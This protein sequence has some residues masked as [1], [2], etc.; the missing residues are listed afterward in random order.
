M[1]PAQP[2]PGVILYGFHESL[3]GMPPL[4]TGVLYVRAKE[5]LHK[6]EQKHNQSEVSKH[7]KSERYVEQN[8]AQAGLLT[9]PGA[10]WNVKRLSS[11]PN[12]IV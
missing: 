12:S 5:K 3:T 8:R 1:P 4:T 7:K 11:G 10:D 2:A 9:S 6:L